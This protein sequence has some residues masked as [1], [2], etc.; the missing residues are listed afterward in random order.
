MAVPSRLDPCGNYVL[1]PD[2]VPVSDGCVE[3][4]RIAYTGEY[5]L[6]RQRHQRCEPTPL[7]CGEPSEGAPHKFVTARSPIQSDID[8]YAWFM[9][10]PS[11]FG[12]RSA[13]SIDEL[14]VLH[15]R[16]RRASHAAARLK[17]AVGTWQSNTTFTSH[18]TV[19]KPDRTVFDLH[20]E[21]SR[22]YPHDDWAIASSE[23]AHNARAALDNLNDR[24]FTKYATGPINAKRIQF[25]ITSTGKAWRSWMQSHRALPD[26]LIVRYQAVQPLTGPYL[27]LQGLA[28][29][30]NQDKHVWLQRV[31]LAL[32]SVS[33]RGTLTVDGTSPDLLLTPIAHGLLLG[34]GERRIHIASAQSSRRIVDLPQT[35]ENDIDPVLHF[36]VGRDEGEDESYTLAELAEIPLRVGHVIDY[37]NGDDSALARYK[38]VPSYMVARS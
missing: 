29:M 12:V 25:P 19:R 3:I 14:S 28:S 10:I 23:L 21:I 9:P 11:A 22:T 15:A 35:A 34:R 38:A 32:T 16:V 24:L 36:H 26:W 8:S 18:V 20:V 4:G 1:R 2:A 7:S 17:V 33:G 37:V 31:S 27:G 30:N 5:L 6:G 13:L